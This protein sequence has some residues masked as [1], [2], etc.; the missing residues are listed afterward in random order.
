MST[1]GPVVLL[2]WELGN[3]LSYVQTLLHLARALAQ[4]GCSP[5]LALKNVVEP[6]PLFDAEP[7]PVV[8]APFTPPP[9]W[10]GSRPFVAT[11]FADILAVWGYSSFEDLWPRVRAW[12]AL[13]DVV[14][15]AMV[16][17]EYAPTLCLAAS[18][19]CPVAAFGS[20]F[21]LPPTDGATFPVLLDGARQ[22]PGEEQL[23]AVVR[24]VQKRRGLPPPATLPKAFPEDERFL[25][26]VPEMDPYRPLR[27]SGHLGPLT[28]LP[29][30]SPWPAR[31]SFFAYLRHSPGVE[32]LLIGLASTGIPGRAYLRSI[33]ADR[34]DHLRRHGV[35]VEEQPVSLADV[36]RDTQVIVHHGGITTSHLAL[37]AGR[38]QLLF[39]EHL[40]QTIN[41]CMLDRLGVVVCPSGQVG[42]SEAAAALR[43]ITSDP[44]YG[45]RAQE[46]ASDLHDRGPWAPLPEIVARCRVLLEPGQSGLHA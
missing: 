32:A 19:R 8:Q 46:R 15:P 5:V 14:R 21:T 7:F 4:E 13:L 28:P 18:G 17:A 43:R 29:P 24:Q 38:P 23:L 3:G 20:G 10:T 45:Q 1:G 39:P 30:P 16:L 25:I 26:V 22:V 42:P 27:P 37:A 35:Q 11:S 12:E 9:E 44:H 33:P 40:E 2:G 41:A 34:R 31:P 6:L 36:L